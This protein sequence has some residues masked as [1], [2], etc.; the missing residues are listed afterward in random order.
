VL[1]KYFG[2]TADNVLDAIKEKKS[3]LPT[4]CWYPPY[5]DENHE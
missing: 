1:T 2:F 4:G 5:Q 3:R